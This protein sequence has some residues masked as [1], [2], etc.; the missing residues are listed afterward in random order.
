MEVEAVDHPGDADAGAGDP[1]PPLAVLAIVRRP[2]GDVM[3]AARAESHRWQLRPL[4]DVDL[5]TGAALGRLEDR[6]NQ[7]RML[8]RRVVGAPAE[9][10]HIRQHLL[11]RRQ[12]LDDEQDVVQAANLLIG[13]DRTGLPGREVVAGLVRNEDEMLPLGI[14]EWEDRTTAAL[15]DPLVLHADVRQ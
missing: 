14:R 1:L 9:A 12:L 7:L 13:R 3:D 5:G 6:D 10:E 15:V 4:R 2:E 8:R 11:G